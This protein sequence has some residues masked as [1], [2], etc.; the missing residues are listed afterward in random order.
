MSKHDPA[1]QRIVEK[2]KKEKNMENEN[3]RKCTCTFTFSG[4]Y[5][6][7][8]DSKTIPRVVPKILDF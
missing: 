3:K 4:P 2:N 5:S 6:R 8:N 1:H 7:D